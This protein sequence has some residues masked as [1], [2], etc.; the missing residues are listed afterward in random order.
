MFVRQFESSLPSQMAEIKKAYPNLSDESRKRIERIFREETAD[1][2]DGLMKDIALIYAKRF[3]VEEMQRIAEF[4]RSA[5]G[6]KLRVESDPLQK[7][8]N[9]VA[10]TW[11]MDVIGRIS[12]RLRQEIK[13]AGPTS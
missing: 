9:G 6:K 12:K 2:I 10:N 4:H 8:L 1:S 7:E 5:A 11:S 13:P 3:S